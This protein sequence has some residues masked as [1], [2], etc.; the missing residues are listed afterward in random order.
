MAIYLSA[1]KDPT[2]QIMRL[3]QF[4]Y[5]PA[6]ILAN[7]G[8]LQ[9]Y[10]KSFGYSS[11]PIA[12][13]GG[14]INTGGYNMGCCGFNTMTTMNFFPV[15][16]GCYGGSNYTT[17]FFMPSYSCLGN[18]N[19][20]LFNLNFGGYDCSYGGCS[21]GSVFGNVTGTG[22]YG[23][24]MGYGIMGGYM[25]WGSGSYSDGMVNTSYSYK[26]SATATPMG[27][28]VV[29]TNPFGKSH[30]YNLGA[31]GSYSSGDGGRA[32]S[33]LGGLYT[34]TRSGGNT[35][36]DFSGIIDLALNYLG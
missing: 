4:A 20:P 21:S 25:P 36:R 24:N 16:S 8:S 6:N 14:S 29:S 34:Q 28:S 27:T 9:P 30:S 5:S 18:S 17:N 15:S 12:L 26:G 22:L 31:L 3:P 1:S 35:N 13:S 32:L 23:Y 33:I 19:G 10:Q 11:L 2:S 7:S